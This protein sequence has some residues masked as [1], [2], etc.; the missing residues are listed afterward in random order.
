MLELM[1]GGWAEFRQRGRIYRLAVPVLKKAY[2]LVISSRSRAGTAK[3]F[4]KKRVA[5]AELLFC[6]LNLLLFDRGR[7]SSVGRALDC[8]AGG[9][10]FH[11]RGRTNTQGLKI[12]EK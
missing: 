10:G 11:S 5:R 9:R 6:L 4:E 7:I 12:T 1:R 3:K 8:R 2:N